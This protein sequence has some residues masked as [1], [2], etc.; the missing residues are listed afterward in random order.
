[1]GAKN[2]KQV[3]LFCFFNTSLFFEAQLHCMIFMENM[4]KGFRLSF[5]I[6]SRLLPDI[7]RYVSTI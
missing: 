7:D 2:S 5:L 3:I 4:Y 6:V 1:M